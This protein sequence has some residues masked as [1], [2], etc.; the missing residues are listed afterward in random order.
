VR[1]LRGPFAALLVRMAALSCFPVVSR[2][3]I[4]GPG[5]NLHS[6]LCRF[7]WVKICARIGP[8]NHT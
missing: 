7:H 8:D 1:F 4:W 5:L 2:E 3:V 6:F